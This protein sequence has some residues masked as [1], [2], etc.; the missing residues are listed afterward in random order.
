MK[1]QNCGKHLCDFQMIIL[2]STELKWHQIYV[3]PIGFM[4][5][6][7]D[8]KEDY[9][10]LSLDLKAHKLIVNCTNFYSEF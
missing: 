5:F 4:H 10:I 6:V 3:K 7:V 1:Q 9:W 2:I 8:K